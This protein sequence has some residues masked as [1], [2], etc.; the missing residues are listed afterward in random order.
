MFDWLWSIFPK[1]HH[2]VMYLY[3]FCASVMVL[4]LMFIL[5]GYFEKEAEVAAAADLPKTKKTSKKTQKVES[6]SQFCNRP[7]WFNWLLVCLT[8]FIGMITTPHFDHI[9]QIIIT[10]LLGWSMVLQVMIE[11]R[12]RFLADEIHYW[13][14]ALGLIHGLMWDISYY[15][16]VTGIGAWLFFW[17]LQKL[18][19]RFNLSAIGGLFSPI[20]FG[21]AGFWL[22]FPDIL[23]MFSYTL[24]IFL[25]FNMVRFMAYLLYFRDKPTMAPYFK[26]N[27]YLTPFCYIGWY[28]LYVFVLHTHLYLKYY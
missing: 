13:M 8:C 18:F 7:R 19:E 11:L 27:L 20:L 3:G 26:T 1:N 12:C 16:V 6:S 9:A 21:A 22:G 2:G 28:Y 15:F 24:L 10:L 4:P 17:G 23:Y 14:I 5:L 25:L